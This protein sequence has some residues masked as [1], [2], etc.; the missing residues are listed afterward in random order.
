MNIC[1]HIYTHKKVYIWLLIYDK[2]TLLMLS[3]MFFY[4]VTY[5]LMF[6]KT[7]MLTL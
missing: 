3:N 5:C 4:K 1:V 2:I 7:Y 6:F